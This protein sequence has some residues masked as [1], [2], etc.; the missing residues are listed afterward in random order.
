MADKKPKGARSGDSTPD[1]SALTDA[2]AGSSTG[3]GYGDASITS[4]RTTV[5]RPATGG[6][7]PAAV[8]SGNIAATGYSPSVSPMPLFDQPEETEGDQQSGLDRAESTDRGKTPGVA[9]TQETD[10]GTSGRA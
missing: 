4:G 2:G 9:R 8:P 1:P 5:D 3:M 10:R 7:L 6:T